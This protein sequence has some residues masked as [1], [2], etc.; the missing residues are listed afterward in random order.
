MIRTN[1]D[2]V[3]DIARVLSLTKNDTRK[4]LKL[5]RK[6][7]KRELLKSGKVR[8]ASIGVLTVKRMKARVGTIYGPK[9]AFKRGSY[10]IAESIK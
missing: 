7:L 9:L 2:I 8:I 5:Y 6:H 10:R 3:E 1:E 4:A